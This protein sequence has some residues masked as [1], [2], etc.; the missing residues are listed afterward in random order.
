MNAGPLFI[1]TYKG[2]EVV[3]D[4]S[5][6]AEVAVLHGPLEPTGVRDILAPWSLVAIRVVGTDERV[7]HALG[8]RE[9]EANTW[10][11]SALVTVDP[12]S[13]L[14]LTSSGRLYRLGVGGEGLDALLLGHLAYALRTWG[15]A[16][17]R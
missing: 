10:I 2:H 12:V 1:A 11:T 3:V 17:V 16:D 9:A 4:V 8:W 15:F 13:S 5:S 7:L 14:I 6:S